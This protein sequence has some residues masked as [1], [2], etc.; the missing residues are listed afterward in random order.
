TARDRLGPDAARMTAYWSR[1]AHSSVAKAARLAGI[2]PERCR[3]VE[4]DQAW[5]LRPDHLAALLAQDRAAGLVPGIIVASMGTTSSTACDP[6]R[7]V[8]E[9]ARGARAWYHVDAAYG[10]TAAILPE[11]RPLLDGLELADSY[12]TNPHKW[13]MTSFDCTAYFVRD[14]EALLSTCRT[15]PEYLRTAHDPE[16]VNYRDWGIP[17]GR[18]FR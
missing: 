17:L 14:V 18:R 13:L 8:G 4:V 1:E 7:A 12:V 15:S 10:G 11:I 5:A 2:P 3:V 9:L 16:V 6:I